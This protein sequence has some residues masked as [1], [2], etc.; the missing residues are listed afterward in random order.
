MEAVSEKNRRCS[1]S[2][3]TD[4]VFYFMIVGPF[5]LVIRFWSDPLRLNSRDSTGWIRT[6]DTDESGEKRGHEQF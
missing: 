4:T 3:H 2:H 1:S 5:A 6:P